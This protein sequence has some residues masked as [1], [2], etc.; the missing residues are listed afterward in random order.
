MSFS[1]VWINMFQLH[2]SSENYDESLL[3][4]DIRPRDYLGFETSTDFYQVF[5][6]K[7]TK[8]F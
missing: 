7:Q 3:T 2:A 8:I 5:R 4:W 1:E 6:L